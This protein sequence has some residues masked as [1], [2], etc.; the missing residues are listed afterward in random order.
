MDAP[1]IGVFGRRNYGK[2]SLV[3]FLTAQNTSIVSDVAGTTTD[4]VRKRMELRGVGPVV[5]ID[6]AGVDDVEDDLGRMRIMRSYEML[7]QCDLALIL[8]TDNRFGSEERNLVQRCEEAGKPYLLI[9]SRADMVSPDAGLLADIEATY[10]KDVFVLSVKNEKLRDPLRQM[11]AAML[12]KGSYVRKGLLDGIVR[13][14]DAVVLV[15]PIDASAPEGRMILPQVQ[16]LRNLMDLHARA[17][18]CQPE[19][20]PTMLSGLKSRPRLVITDSQVFA[21][22]E[23]LVPKEVELTSFSIVLA[24]SKGPFENYIQGTPQIDRLQ[25]GD[26]VLILESCTHDVTCEDIGRVKIPRLLKKYTGKELQCEV[27]AG[28]GQSQYPI[29]EY[30]LVIQCGGCVV[31]SQQLL[32]RLMPA[33]EAGI[34]VTNYGLAIAYMTGIFNRAIAPFKN[35]E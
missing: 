7:K 9:Y 26:R 2:S 34:P 17:L 29:D 16:V 3:N 5:W 21:M 25:D 11:V 31:S 33:L 20:L 28:L 14:D 23:K 18:F 30:K 35:K 22:V 12:P 6:T 10:H 15:T 24:R 32:A 8:F 13:A 27:V 4:P 19:E 1:H